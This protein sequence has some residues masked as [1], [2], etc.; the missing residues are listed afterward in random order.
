VEKTEIPYSEGEKTL[1]LLEPARNLALTYAVTGLDLLYLGVA[2][3]VFPRIAEKSIFAEYRI[4]VLY[5]GYAGFLHLGLL[6][7]FYLES[8]HSNSLGRKRALLRK[9]RRYL[10]GFLF[11]LAPLVA[12]IFVLLN[13]SASKFTVA[14][15]I[16]SWF[17]LNGQTLCNYA[18]QTQNGFNRF[19]IYNCAGR[20]VGLVFVCLIAISG[21]VSTVTLD[22]SFLLP[23]AVAVVVAEVL[24]SRVDHATAVQEGAI[25]ETRPVTLNWRP[26]AHLY[27]ANVFATLA[28]SVDKVVVAAQFAK[29]IFADYSFA[30]S[31]SS[32]VLYAGDGVATATLPL[33]VKTRLV[34]K[35]TLQPDLIWIGLYWFAPFAF[36]PARLFVE[37]WYPAYKSSETYLGF[38]S[39]TLP[40]IIYCKSYCISTSIAAKASH[41][42]S[43][44]NFAG[45]VSIAIG[46]CGAE[47]Y[48][49]MPISVCRGWCGGVFIWAA[50]S[51]WCLSRNDEVNVAPQLRQG[52]VSAGL[53]SLA[54]GASYYAMRYGALAGPVT[55]LL[56]TAAII[57]L[58]A[59]VSRTRAR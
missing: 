25:D 48:D 18:A 33:L 46:I 39:A 23:I 15:L 40:A 8:L 10:Y 49:A 58:F 57:L 47:Y 29:G 12:F 24:S 5:S 22:I 21:S 37:H 28:L 34:G 36:W 1:R 50:L 59:V 54:F 17:L 55:H 20:C 4:L 9:T 14:A 16:L 35:A 52:L 42:Q 2:V 13:P 45:I 27:A 56:L 19:F 51:C 31:L 53:S 26:C 43:R 44:V 41:L 6:S 11:L 30:F 3:L 7:G 38:F 32:L